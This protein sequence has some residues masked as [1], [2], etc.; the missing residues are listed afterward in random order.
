MS[1]KHVH[2]KGAFSIV[3]LI[4]TVK[5]EGAFAKTGALALFI[6]VVRGENVNGEKVQKLEIEAYEEKADEVLSSICSDIKRKYGL[7]D[8]Q[9]HHFLG[10][11]NVGEDLVYVVVAGSHREN[12]FPA[13]REAVERYKREAPIFKKEYVTAINGKT[14]AYWVTEHEV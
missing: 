3:D 7:V 11:F 13:L 4:G 2:Q 8:V 12:V 5:N 1:G 10:E 6:G 9:I 14:K